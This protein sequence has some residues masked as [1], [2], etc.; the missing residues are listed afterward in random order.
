MSCSRSRRCA[1]VVARRGFTLVELLVVIAIIGVLVAM[2]LP[3]VQ[4]AREAARR[5]SC[6]NN[7]KQLCL[8]LHNYHDT[9]RRF[10]PGGVFNPSVT[11]PSWSIQA[12]ILPFIEQ[13]NLQDLIDWNLPYSAQPLV[14][15]QRI[16][17]LICPSEVNDRERPDGALTHY[18]LNYG[19]NYGT[20]FVYDPNTRQ[21]GNGLFYPNSA[22]G[23]NS[24][25]DGTS[26]TIAFAEVKA[27]NPYLRDGANPNAAG[28][29]IPANP[30]AVVGYGG[31]FKAD[32]GHTEWVDSR[33]HQ[34]GVT[35]TF[36]PNTEF[37]FTNSGQI[38]D[39]DFTSSREGGS[40]TNLTYATVTSRSYHPGGA[41]ISL[42]DGSTRFVAETIDIITWRSLTTRDGREVV[43]NY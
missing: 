28:T 10:P 27:W 43:G 8:A 30:A 20:W 1:S 4:A 31:N 14:T 21:G 9:Y 11:N 18:P 5:S 26:S 3:A 19:G 29:A 25:I 23:F 7:L 16:D 17:T 15:R 41:Q 42:T 33:V 24:V 36:P 35:G 39:V 38:Y 34:S 6:S 12:R 2:L 37:P 32:S 13:K 22:T 40:L